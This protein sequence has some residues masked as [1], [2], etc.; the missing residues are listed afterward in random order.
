M[1]L[2]MR[3]GESHLI[4][5]TILTHDKKH[6]TKEKNNYFWESKSQ[7][8]GAQNQVKRDTFQKKKFFFPANVNLERKEQKE[9]F[10]PKA[11]LIF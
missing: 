8:M 3:K 10:T 6:M 2:S 9:I 4:I 1:N 5:F 7:W 11:V